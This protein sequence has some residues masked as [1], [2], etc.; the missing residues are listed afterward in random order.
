MPPAC[1]PPSRSR[2]ALRN[3]HRPD[4]RRRIRFP[5][6]VRRMVGATEATTDWNRIAFGLDCLIQS[7]VVESGRSRLTKASP[8]AHDC[9]VQWGAARAQ[10]RPSHPPG[11][12]WGG[13]RSAPSHTPRGRHALQSERLRRPLSLW[14]L[15]GNVIVKGAVFLTQVHTVPAH[16]GWIAL[17]ARGKAAALNSLNPKPPTQSTHRLGRL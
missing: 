4:H 10:R 8:S 5:K 9:R 11:S 6:R 16:A 7:V 17:L 13:A 3:P 15:L 12:V 14:H 1:R 2:L